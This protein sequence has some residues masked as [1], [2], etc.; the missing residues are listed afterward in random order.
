MSYNRADPSSRYLELRDLY[1]TIYEWGESFFDI[2]PERI[3]PGSSLCAQAG[4]IERLVVQNGALA[5]LDYGSGKS[6]Q[7]ETSTI[8]DDTGKV[9]PSVIDF[10]GVDEVVCYDP[11]YAPYSNQYVEYKIG[12]AA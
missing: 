7:C 11:R 10:W 4:R 5:A 3:F 6:M 2:P 1:R 9:W 12:N 8:R